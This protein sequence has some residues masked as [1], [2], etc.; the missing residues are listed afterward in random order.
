ML[1]DY[2]FEN[3]QFSL[4]LIKKKKKPSWANYFIAITVDSSVPV[5]QDTL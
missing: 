3:Q 2:G 5:W 4:L 1:H